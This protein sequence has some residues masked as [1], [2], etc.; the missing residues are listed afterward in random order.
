MASNLPSILVN[1]QG[2]ESPGTGQG[3]QE[4]CFRHLGQKGHIGLQVLLPG[5]S[6]QSQLQK[7][8]RWQVL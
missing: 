7:S 1:S 2:C 6:V 4:L 5:L 3:S 8:L